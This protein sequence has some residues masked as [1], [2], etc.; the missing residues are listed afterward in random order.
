MLLQSDPC[1]SVTKSC[2][3]SNMI[4]MFI[5]DETLEEESDTNKKEGQEKGTDGTEIG[6][7]MGSS[8]CS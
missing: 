6:G 7:K 2:W 8:S 4:S 5:I 1:I 3:P